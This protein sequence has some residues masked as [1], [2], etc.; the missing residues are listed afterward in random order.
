MS[1]QW[2]YAHEGQ[3]FGPV[4]A[5]QL[6]QAADAGQLYPMDLVWK[7]G[8][9]N[10]VP[11]SSIKGLFSAAALA[12]APPPAPMNIAPVVQPGTIPYTSS[13]PNPLVEAA[14]MHAERAWVWDLQTVPVGTGEKAQLT[15]AGID[16]EP[17]QRYFGWRRS[18]MLLVVL[19]T[20][21]SAIF[22]TIVVANRGFAHVSGFG[23]LAEGL[24]LLSMYCLP[25]A[26]LAAAAMWAQARRSF[27]VLLL[28]GTVGM[29]V[30]VAVAF[31]PL[32]WMLKTEGGGLGLGSVATILAATGMVPYEAYQKFILLALFPAALR[33]CLRIKSL[34][35]E[36]IFA[37]WFLVAAAPVQVLMV[38]MA[39]LGLSALWGDVLL[40]FSAVFLMAAPCLYLARA[41]LFTRPL[42]A[43]VNRQP[44]SQIE[45]IYTGAVGMAAVF[46]VIFL[47]TK[48]LGA[49]DGHLFGFDEKCVLSAW[50]IPF[51]WVD[52]L[53]RSLFVTLVIADL[54]LR[55]NLSAWRSLASFHKTVEAPGYD[56]RMSRLEN[57][58]T[59]VNR[60]AIAT[61]PA[62]PVQ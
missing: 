39:F 23:S 58:L 42:A 17:T 26:A 45:W 57:A 51:Y 20:F 53:G 46:L 49:G 31:L 5:A 13:G 21:V 59:Q 30:P 62:Y 25:A 48:K 41:R 10:W 47:L 3:Q 50:R 7:E 15:A 60:P 9:A 54:V 55:A 44:I 43:D 8:L 14:K 16:D 29:L 12:A 27:L 35:P 33:A 34:L 52:Y 11:A 1:Q 37:G 24:L 56:E 22:H 32:E 40:L 19:P 4:V 28:G 18:L 6:K 38:A 61:A 2:Y 36:S